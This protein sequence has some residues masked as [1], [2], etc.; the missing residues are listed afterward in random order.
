MISLNVVE[1]V[2]LALAVTGLV[3]VIWEIAVKDARLFREIATDVRR[4]AEPSV[5]PTATY[6][7]RTPLSLGEP[8]NTNGLR[9]AA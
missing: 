2:V 5:R 4:M 8:A 1:I 9:K 6:S 7:A 3:A